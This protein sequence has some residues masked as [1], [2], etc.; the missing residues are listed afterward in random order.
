MMLFVADMFDEVL[1]YG[2]LIVD[3]LRGYKQP[4]FVYIPPKAELRGGAW[5]V[6][7]PTI[8][9]E[10]MEMYCD[11]DSRQVPRGRE[12]EFSGAHVV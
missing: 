2:A 4:C 8:N 12:G 11:R 1:K 10:V 9:S 5:V 7:D 3:A 6:L